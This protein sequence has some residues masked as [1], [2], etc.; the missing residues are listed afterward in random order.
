MRDAAHL[1]LELVYRLVAVGVDQLLE[2]VLELVALLE[3]EAAVVQ[4]PVRSR[5]I[6]DVDL[7]V[8]PVVGGHLAVDLVEYEVLVLPDQ[9]FRADGFTL[10]LDFTG[11]RE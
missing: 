10:L 11:Y 7:D 8:V 6:H 4:L 9:D 1:V 5:E 2:A 3:Y